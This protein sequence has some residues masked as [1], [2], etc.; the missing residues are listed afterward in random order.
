MA[1]A[2]IPLEFA[3]EEGDT[4]LLRDPGKGWICKIRRPRFIENKLEIVDGKVEVSPAFYNFWFKEFLVEDRR[5]EEEERRRQEEKDLKPFR[6][7]CEYFYS[8]IGLFMENRE[9]ILKEPRFA[10][11]QPPR[12]LY[13]TMYASFGGEKVTLGELLR[14]WTNEPAYQGTCSCGGKAYLYHW[15]GSPLS[16]SLFCRNMRC[17]KCGRDFEGETLEKRYITVIE[18]TQIRK[19]YHPIKSDAEPAP[20]EELVAFLEHRPYI[21]GADREDGDEFRN[22]GGVSGIA[23]PDGNMIM[24]TQVGNSLGGEEQ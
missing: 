19:Q 13:G 18:R 7:A 3:G 5:K 10:N 12:V 4:I 16:G 6:D 20:V 15:V 2:K 9:S 24:G 17:G 14:I 1:E 23:A 8:R 21:P 22:I 11:I